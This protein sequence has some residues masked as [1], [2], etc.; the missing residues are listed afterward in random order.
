MNQSATLSLA[1]MLA[2]GSSVGATISASAQSATAPDSTTASGA[3]PFT[4]PSARKSDQVDSYHG[5][6]VADPYRWLEDPD[7]PET[8]A[9]I[10]AQNMLTTTFLNA[11]PQREA[12][13]ARLG[14]LWNYEKYD[15]P[16]KRGD[17]YFYALNTG[18]QNQ[19]VLYVQEGR[20]GTARAL[21]DP[22]TL[23]S[24]GTVALNSRVPSSKGKYLAYGVATAGSDWVEVRVRDVASGAD[25]ADTVRWIKFSVPS[26]SKDEKGFVY[27]RY[28]QPSQDKALSQ[29]VKNQK[30][31]YHAVGTPQSSDRLVYERSD[32]PDW[33]WGTEIS[34]DGRFLIISASE[35]SDP[36]T[37]IFYMDLKD[38]Q[39]P[40]F[41][42]KMVEVLGAGDAEYD[43][44]GNIGDLLYIR[45]DK[46]APRGRIIAVDVKDPFESKWVT[47]VPESDDVL[48]GARFI[49]G[50]LFTTVLKNAHSAIY[51][52]AVPALSSKAA[53]KT[54]A[55]LGE[56]VEVK[57]PGL[58][59]LSGL[60]GN[61]HDSEVF[62][63]FM[64]YLAPTTI[65]E[66]DIKSGTSKVF[67]SPK[68]GFDPSLYETRQVFYASKDGTRIPMFIT[69][70]K[71]T[72]LDGKN[73]M[74]LYGYG[75]FNI[76][77]TP[78]FNPRTLVWL[79]KG[80]IYAVANL[81]GGGEYGSSWHRA[82]TLHQKQ[83]VFDDFISAAE[84]L[85]SEKYTSSSKLAINGGSNGGLLVGAVV[86][87]RPDLF[88][89]AVPE[90]GVMDMLRFQK[91][92]IGWAW[93]SDYG[94]SDDSKQFATLYKYSPIHN[95]KAGTK[96]PPVMVMTADHDDRVV[97]G[98]SF[99]YAAALQAAQGGAAPVLIRIESKAGH[100]AGKPTSKQ[101]E[102]AADRF[103]FLMQALGM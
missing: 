63:G 53:G 14:A 44:V 49:G 18:L 81:R 93:T 37:R 5:V 77:L 59:S 51:S 69:M 35:G 22:N 31:Y 6:Q 88:G 8:R 15:T 68:L 100:G 9:W 33:I 83:N 48:T 102:E 34:D 82:G 80:G 85:I 39:K 52:Y 67:R 75:G 87:Q 78:A 55:A 4:Y 13:R 97:P 30:I 21:L 71:G 20:S 43:V 17:R 36:K 54:S 40:D 1:A 72:V 95:L 73:P 26:W 10:S 3:R 101:I 42:G 56:R 94:S 19:A 24:D 38:P 99:K 45:T 28:D 50:R 23:A 32:R 2:V 29:I 103:G 96:Y 58:G 66:Y 25:L 86:N 7:S 79:E 70:K 62:Y 46:G 41:S 74:L 84:Y 98:H 57:L 60:S 27:A 64:S 92:T 12:L 91:F 11:I 90:V 76:S 61:L 89:A 47:V 65:Y 16:V